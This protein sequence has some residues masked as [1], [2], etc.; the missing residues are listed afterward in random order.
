MRGD[1]ASGE[2]RGGKYKER[3]NNELYAMLDNK[4]RETDL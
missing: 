2:G 4:D 3:M 1:V